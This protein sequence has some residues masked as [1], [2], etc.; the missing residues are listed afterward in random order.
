MTRYQYPVT[1]LLV[2]I[3][4]TAL[5]AP[6]GVSLEDAEQW[7][8][9]QQK[10]TAKQKAFAE[11]CGA[12]VTAR[13]D[14]KSYQGIS[15]DAARAT[16]A[17]LLSFDSLKDVCRTDLGKAA[18]KQNVTRLSCR[19]S[20]DGTRATLNGTTLVVHLDPKSSG[21]QGDKPGSYSWKS[22]IKERFK[23][24]KAASAVP[25]GLSL[26]DA[27]Q[28]AEAAERLEKK[29]SAINEACSTK[30]SASYDAKSY[31][32]I[33]Y[34]DARATAAC[35]HAADTLKTIC[36][37]SSGREAVSSKVSKMVCRLSSNGTRVSL[38]GKQLVVHLD[39]KS[40]SIQ[41]DAAGSYSWKSAIKERL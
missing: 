35:Q 41:G 31:A 16:G 3:A 5:A 7:D 19:Y 40:G 12:K 15:Y 25:T 14:E 17:C 24:P 29:E 11:A 38:S 8:A 18:V 33:S 23:A 30:I 6:K 2:A 10:L 1:A 22:A 21:I 28:W 37:T 32:K 4:G 20:T 39:P 36:G 34:D 27:E 13:F 26:D 9:A